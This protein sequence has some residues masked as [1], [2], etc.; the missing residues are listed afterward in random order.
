MGSMGVVMSQSSSGGSGTSRNRGE[1]G[2]ENG[3]RSGS[4]RSSSVSPIDSVEGNKYDV[5]MN[6]NSRDPRAGTVDDGDD[7]DDDDDDDDE[8][9]KRVR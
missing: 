4:S 9:G 1:S 2:Y 7:D 5:E 8:Y 6:S 3:S